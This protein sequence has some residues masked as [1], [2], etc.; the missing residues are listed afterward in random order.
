[1]TTTPA[2][3]FEKLS[4]SYAAMLPLLSYLK[5]RLKYDTVRWLRTYGTKDDI[6]FTT[7]IKGLDRIYDKLVRKG[8]WLDSEPDLLKMATSGKELLDDLLGIRFICFDPYR[9]YDLISYFLITERVVISKRQFYASEK[10]SKNHPIPGYLEA[11]GFQ[12][13]VKS[14]REYED[15]NFIMRFAHPIDRY[16]GS[17]AHPFTSLA[18]ASSSTSQ[19]DRLKAVNATFEAIQNEPELRAA[20]PEIPI[21]CQIVT[22]TQHIYNRTQRPQYE[23]ILQG[24]ETEPSIT[25]GELTDFTERLELLKLNLLSIDQN[26]YSIH[27]KLGIQYGSDLK[28][29]HGGLVSITGRLP[30]DDALKVNERLK[31]LDERLVPGVIDNTK[32]KL[33][34]VRA[35]SRM[36]SEIDGIND[37]IRARSQANGDIA[38]SDLLSIVDFPEIEHPTIVFWVLQRAV[39]LMICVILLYTKDQ[40]VRQKILSRVRFGSFESGVHTF[41]DPDILLARLFERL[42]HTDHAVFTKIS[43]G[44][45]RIPQWKDGYFHPAVFVDPLVQWRYASFMY[46]RRE[47]ANAANEMR[48]ALGLHA[49]LQDFESPDIPFQYPSRELFLRRRVEYEICDEIANLR[50]AP[51]TLAGML[52]LTSSM[53]ANNEGWQS[54]LRQVAANQDPIEKARALCL[55]IRLAMC[56]LTAVRQENAVKAAR[57]L[58]EDEFKEV[59]T[60]VQEAEPNF[61]RSWWS[62]T[63]ALMGRDTEASLK[64]F[65]TKAQG[66]GYHPIERRMFEQ[67]CGRLAELWMGEEGRLVEPPEFATRALSLLKDQTERLR[68]TDPIGRPQ[69]DRIANL[70]RDLLHEMK[71]TANYDS[72]ALRSTLSSIASDGMA[73]PSVDATLV[74]L[75]NVLGL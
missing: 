75:R 5:A 2:R 35:L 44:T 49:S 14:D 70:I 60:F 18:Q 48:V 52:D 24:K 41:V 6:V 26:V 20:I 22:A 1:M 30:P 72:I 64:S 28:I 68:K 40:E 61:E 43:L 16:F 3:A 45:D 56:A 9:V 13:I 11:N 38:G 25:D 47:Y 55:R 73:Y 8:H 53:L 29:G 32:P 58:F 27:K 51:A 65:N 63:M 69:L 4:E 33:G 54:D 57:R 42:E 15:I 71:R 50:F 19:N 23:F 12:R 39:L 62:L 10:A 36:L 46:R 37:T 31:S 59:E 67:S 17:G 66:P 7:R 34:R 21:E 74:G